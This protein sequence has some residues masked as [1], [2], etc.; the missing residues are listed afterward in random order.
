MG[1]YTHFTRTVF[2]TN[3]LPRAQRESI[4]SQTIYSKGT[5]CDITKYQTFLT[6]YGLVRENVCHLCV[7]CPMLCVLSVR[8]E[9]TIVFFYYRQIK[10]PLAQHSNLQQLK[11][12][13][14]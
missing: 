3:I 14:N 9:V 8:K 5:A 12:H 4:T 13:K 1:L 6:K 11:L 2:L 10:N 7:I